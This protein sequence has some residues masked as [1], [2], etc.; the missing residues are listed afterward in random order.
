MGNAFRKKWSSD[1][2]SISKAARAHRAD[3]RK[4]WDLKENHWRSTEIGEPYKHIAGSYHSSIRNAT[5]GFGKNL[6]S[7]DRSTAASHLF[8]AGQ[9]GAVLADGL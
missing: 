9:E 6:H 3:E 1:S 4:L 2:E 8:F 5:P 7:L